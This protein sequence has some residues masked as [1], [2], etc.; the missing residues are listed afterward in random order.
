MEFPSKTGVKQARYYM[1][2]ICGV[3]IIWLIYMVHLMWPRGDEENTVLNAESDYELPNCTLLCP[4]IPLNLTE[5]GH[6]ELEILWLRGE[7]KA[8]KASISK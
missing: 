7:R 5:V 1:I 8:L 4:E 6:T 3:H 2:S